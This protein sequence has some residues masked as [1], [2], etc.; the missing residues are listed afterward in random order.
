MLGLAAVLLLIS[1]LLIALGFL[2]SSAPV[3][4]FGLAP[5]VLLF[6]MRLRL[7]VVLTPDSLSYTG[8]IRTKRLDFSE[9]GSAVRS[10][11]S[12]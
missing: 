3:V 7:R 2:A 12:G 11:E 8:L 1:A 10:V 4:C 6:A 5:L 9:I